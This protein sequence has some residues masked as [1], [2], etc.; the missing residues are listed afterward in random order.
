VR[1][2]IPLFIAL[3]SMTA[4][5]A[6]SEI[7]SRVQYCDS[8]G[9]QPK[10]C[11]ITARPDQAI[12]GVV[13]AG[14][15]SRT[16]CGGRWNFSAESRII[17]VWGGCR[18]NFR[19]S[20]R[21]SANPPVTITDPAVPV[22]YAR[23]PALEAAILRSLQQSPL[24]PEQKAQ[25][26]LDRL[27]FGAGRHTRALVRVTRGEVD[28]AK[29]DAAILRFIM[30]SLA[31]RNYRR[32]DVEKVLQ[33]EFPLSQHSYQ[34]L[35]SRSSENVR[36][37]RAFHKETVRL[38][39]LHAATPSA[40]I[41]AQLN[42]ARQ[43][44]LEAIRIINADRWDLWTAAQGRLIANSVSAGYAL[45]YK[46]AYLW[47]NRLN[48][49]GEKVAFDLNDY[50]RTISSHTHSKFSDML[51]ASARH[52]GMS[53][54]LNNYANRV[55]DAKGI[56]PNEDYGRELLELHTLG[57]V[58]GVGSSSRSYNLRDV[59]ASA[60][61]MAG[62]SVSA[63]DSGRTFTFIPRYNPTGGKTL[64]G[65]TFA[66]GEQGGI[67]YLNYLSTHP[68]TN[69]SIVSMLV[70]YFVTDALGEES[71][72]ELRR[73]LQEAYSSSRGDLNKIYQELVSH[74]VF[75]SA[76]AFRAKIRD[77]FQQVVSILRQSGYNATNLNRDVLVKA[78]R[79]TAG[80]G[81]DLFRCVP[82]T[83]YSINSYRWASA[84][85]VMSTVRYAFDNA[86]SVVDGTAGEAF[87]RLEGLA[88]DAKAK[89]NPIT[90]NYYMR[91]ALYNLYGHRW[92][93]SRYQIPFAKFDSM[94]L[95]SIQSPDAEDRQPRLIRTAAGIFNG[96]LELSIQ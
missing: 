34:E 84:N 30:H 72:V 96:S 25:H 65:M 89:G 66:D 16:P 95:K 63:T 1:K 23:N 93:A 51:I 61:I 24:S 94:V 12:L 69:S 43:R 77:P 17:R 6:F 11:A 71:V 46:L 74:P 64:L 55:D 26:A 35:A 42:T 33:A 36:N 82:P 9:Y 47:F 53:I 18:A 60:R 4:N 39:A 41:L 67:D 92:F 81:Q 10:T 21:E 80:M 14:Q 13:F 22:D 78:A 79:A 73:D 2:L 31:V 19:V 52:P 56:L 75:W 50:I 20:L 7:E 49:N 44:E 85:N 37:Y 29:T 70:G 90:A 15:V 8:R 3:A 83:G 88:A 86:T 58:A 54:Y 48:I 76:V 87:D 68:L 27:G 28:E 59:R 91:Q 5:T 40:S 32:Q 38:E 62:W 57:I 45:H